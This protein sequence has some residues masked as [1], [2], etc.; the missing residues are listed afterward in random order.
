MHYNLIKIDENVSLHMYIDLFLNKCFFIVKMT[1]YLISM[2][3]FP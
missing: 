2:I 3:D 1:I